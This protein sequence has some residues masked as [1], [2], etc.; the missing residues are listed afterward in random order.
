MQTVVGLSQTAVHNNE[1]YEEY[2][3]QATPLQLD[4]SLVDDGG[5]VGSD[6]E[7]SIGM[8][9]L[10]GM[11]MNN[12]SD[13]GVDVDIDNDDVES[14]VNTSAMDMSMATYASKSP[15]RK[16]QRQQSLHETRDA[17]QKTSAKSL[18]KPI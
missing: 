11:G 12:L 18:L 4:A 1:R 15:E 9:G 14:D 8:N 13:V 16:S 2:T 7:N 5:S 3:K 6:D 17:L 10:K